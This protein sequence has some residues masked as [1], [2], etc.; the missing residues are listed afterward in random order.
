MRGI[1]IPDIESEDI[2]IPLVVYA[3]LKAGAIHGE[4]AKKRLD[5]IRVFLSERQVQVSSGISIEM[6]DIYASLYDQL[7]I[8]GTAPAALK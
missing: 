3:E 7:R 5:G 4:H 6:V 8:K 1:P 2:Y